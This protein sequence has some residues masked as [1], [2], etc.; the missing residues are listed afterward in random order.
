[1]ENSNLDELMA[2]LR[3][4]IVHMFY[5]K[6]DGTLREAYGTLNFN[7]VP[8]LYWPA[9]HRQN[10]D[11]LV[12]Y[13]DMEAGLTKSEDETLER[14]IENINT[15]AREYRCP[16]MIV[17]TGYEA[18]RPEAGKA[19]MTKLIDAARNR[20]GGNCPGVFYWAPEAEGH[21]PLGAFQNHRPT[22][23]M[24]AFRAK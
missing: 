2:Q 19:F 21:Y 12:N 22:V 16:V 4:N 14:V 7:Y 24:E 3:N 20:T 10:R 23:I 6:K 18:R 5:R 13:W 1:M 11:Y 15:L 8:M 17:E 9:G